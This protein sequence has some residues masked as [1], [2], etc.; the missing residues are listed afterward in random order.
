MDSIGENRKFHGTAVPVKFSQQPWS[1]ACPYLIMG[2]G[3]PLG[4]LPITNEPFNQLP[5][6]SNLGAKHEHQVSS[7]EYPVSSTQ[8]KPNLLAPQINV[9][10]VKTKNYEQ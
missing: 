9:S 10:S 8:N 4:E 6:T 7:I 3:N 1:E 2:G 5:I